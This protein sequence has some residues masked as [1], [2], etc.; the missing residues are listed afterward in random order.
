VL[1]CAIEKFSE[2][3]TRRLRK[4]LTSVLLSIRAS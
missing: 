1:R 2:R 4:F 3:E